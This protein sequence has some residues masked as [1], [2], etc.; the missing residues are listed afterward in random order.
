MY[1]T[2]MNAEVCSHCTIKCK[3]YLYHEYV[4]RWIQKKSTNTTAAEDGLP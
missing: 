3:M 4:D 2:S 1:A